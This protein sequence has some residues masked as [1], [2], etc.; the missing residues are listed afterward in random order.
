MDQFI[1]EWYQM[2]LYNIDDMKLA[3]ETGNLTPAEFK[4][5]TGQ[6]YETTTVATS[7]ATSQVVSTSSQAS[8]APSMANQYVLYLK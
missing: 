7:Q 6:D 1:I 2:G 3:V 8:Q 5:A 4:E